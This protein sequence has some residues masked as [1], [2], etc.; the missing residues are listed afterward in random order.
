[1][2]TTAVAVA[3]GGR[4]III[5]SGSFVSENQPGAIFASLATKSTYRAA[6]TKRPR[7]TAISASVVGLLVLPV[8]TKSILSSGASHP[9]R[10]S[11]LIA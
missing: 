5:R 2:A 4:K 9:R 1:M 8:S 7:S 3:S 11:A 10:T 6:I